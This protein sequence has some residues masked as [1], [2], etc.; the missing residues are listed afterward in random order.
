[1]GCTTYLFKEIQLDF[2][3]S[4]F[5]FFPKKS[6]GRT[7]LHNFRRVNEKFL[8]CYVCSSRLPKCGLKSISSHEVLKNLGGGDGEGRGEHDFFSIYT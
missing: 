7:K 3:T 1:M 2:F 6:R 8:F 5:H 4:C